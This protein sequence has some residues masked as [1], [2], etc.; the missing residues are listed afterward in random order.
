MSTAANAFRTIMILICLGMCCWYL[1][2][3]DAAS[4]AFY[5]FLM[6]FWQNVALHSDR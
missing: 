5:G 6:L 4:L 3:K 1:F 2:Q